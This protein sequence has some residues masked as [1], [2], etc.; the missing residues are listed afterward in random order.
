MSLFYPDL[1]WIK[2]V[3]LFFIAVIF[4]LW[5][6]GVFNR[7]NGFNFYQNGQL[8]NRKSHQPVVIVF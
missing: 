1:L 2:I 7:P 3:L 6:A 8:I 5:G 4:C